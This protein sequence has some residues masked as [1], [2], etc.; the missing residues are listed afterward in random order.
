MPD[1][2]TLAFEDRGIP[3][4]VRLIQ[5][6]SVETQLASL[7][8]LYNTISKH[9]NIIKL[10]QADGI[11]PLVDLLAAPDALVRQRS[12]AI[13][14][15]IAAIFSG[16]QAIFAHKN[17]FPAFLN[18][19]TDEDTDVRQTIHIAICNLC[20]GL[21]VGDAVTRGAIPVLVG[22]VARDIDPVKVLALDTLYYCTER[23]EQ[24][25][26]L[27]LKEGVLPVLVNLLPS[28]NPE[29]VEK[30]GSLL[31]SLTT[32]IDGK[33]AALACGAIPKLVALLGTDS[34]EALLTCSE[35]LLNV[36]TTLEGQVEAIRVGA[37][38]RTMQMLDLELPI[39][40]RITL[41]KL[42][43]NLA[44]NPDGRQLL[45]PCADMLAV[46]STEADQ[47][48]ADDIRLNESAREAHRLVT[49]T[50]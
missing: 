11:T 36:T 2:V 45:L 39:T 35:A 1:A 46:L 23:I 3:K 10:L 17:A 14:A 41:V 16:R 28:Q 38:E 37:C 44:V 13:L 21:Q 48:G 12:A 50:P 33:N 49:F 31:S 22:C 30:A 20:S 27:S 19:T 8:L 40:M 24:A 5:H 29:V 43:G 4:L 9:E 26:H 6:E 7:A 47:A 32:H 18:S 25:I 34:L 42:I 15:R